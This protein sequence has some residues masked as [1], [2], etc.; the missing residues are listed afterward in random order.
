MRMR[1]RMK[2]K[3]KVNKGRRRRRRNTLWGVGGIKT[4]TSLRSWPRHGILPVVLL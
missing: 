1:M 3:M 2:V 4:H